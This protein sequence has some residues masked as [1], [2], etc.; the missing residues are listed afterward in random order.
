MGALHPGHASLIVRAKQACDFVV[1]SVFVN[2]TQF[3]NS[4]DFETYP[5]TLEHDMRVAQQAG[6]DAVFTPDV[7]ELYAGNLTVESVDYGLL[8]S[9][10]EG[11]MRKGHFDGVVAVVRKLFR[12]VQADEAFFGEKDLQQLAVIRRLAQEEFPG[13]SVV[14][15]PL[16]REED[17]L[18][19]SSRNVRLVG[20]SRQQA[21]A[22][23]GWLERLKAEVVQQREIGSVLDAIEREAGV[24]ETVELEYVDVVDGQTFE[25]VRNGLDE[26]RSFAV[27]AAHVGGV[28]LIDNC[29]LACS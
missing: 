13:L 4:T 18:A 25:P 5:S 10:Y 29:R 21:L 15:C 7:D 24:M 3:N 16:V 12:A 26:G 19:M 23:Y 28:R 9:A 22:L 6:A 11:Q 20:D 27:I 1:V 14:G 2:P 17:G 8:T